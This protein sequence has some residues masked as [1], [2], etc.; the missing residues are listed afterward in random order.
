MLRSISP[1]ISATNDVDVAPLCSNSLGG[2][3][4]KLFVAVFLRKTLQVAISDSPSGKSSAVLIFSDMGLVGSRGGISVKL[5]N[6][7][8]VNVSKPKVW[9]IIAC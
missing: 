6:D 4:T 3:S 8:P 5:R 1:K 9:G 2:D 7:P